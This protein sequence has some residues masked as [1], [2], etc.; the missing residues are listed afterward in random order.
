MAR[1]NLRNLRKKYKS[2][3]FVCALIDQIE[4]ILSESGGLND[5]SRQKITGQAQR[6]NVSN[7]RVAGLLDEIAASRN[8]SPAGNSQS[9]T[10]QS[11]TRQS[12]TRGKTEDELLDI[13]M[14]SAPTAAN[15]S[16]TAATTAD[17]GSSK[18]PAKVV[19]PL[20]REFMRQAEPIIARERGVNSRSQALLD[21]L[22]TDLELTSAQ[23]EEGFALLAG[24]KIQESVESKPRSK[25][26]H[27]HVRDS[28]RASKK[29]EITFAD[30]QIFIDTAAADFGLDRPNAGQILHRVCDELNVDFISQQEALR[31]IET[32]FEK[33]WP[34]GDTLSDKSRQI[35]YEDGR[36]LGLSDQQI[37]SLEKD[38]AERR[39]NRRE[40]MATRSNVIVS[41]SMWLVLAVACIICV[42]SLTH[43]DSVSADA[44]PPPLPEYEERGWWDRQMTLD[45]ID[46]RNSLHSVHEWLEELIEQDEATRSASYISF[47]G[48][49]PAANVYVSPQLTDRTPEEKAELSRLMAGIISLEPSATCANVLFEQ[50]ALMVASPSTENRLQPE[51]YLQRQWVM[52]TLL[53]ARSRR[54]GISGRQM[55]AANRLN[56]EFGQTLNVSTAPAEFAHNARVELARSQFA[57]LRRL[58]R[59]AADDLWSVFD[60]IQAEIGANVDPAELEDLNAA[61]LCVYIESGDENWLPWKELIKQLIRTADEDRLSQLEQCTGRCPVVQMKQYIES[62]I[63]AKRLELN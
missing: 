49:D 28:L 54:G 32:E 40:S 19:D 3:P 30:E 13:L 25:R 52:E 58:A 6:L 36:R 31:M 10:G 14:D 18:E 61:M 24:R 46:A 12:Q 59:F 2:E 48:I 9:Q 21:E 16:S 11:P 39:H 41:S 43:R 29:R 50:L 55:L 47:F 45:A 42:V 7:D 15:S 37:R 33:Q 34:P 20:V 17:T 35:I 62:F 22:A 23:K 51:A 57:T 53:K 27:D 8:H 5:E 44:T 1:Y 4:V 38:I 26:F 56:N 60:P 63:R